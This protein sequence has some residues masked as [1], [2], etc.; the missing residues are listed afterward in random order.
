MIRSS[1][2]TVRFGLIG[3]CIAAACFAGC[4]ED[5]VQP[6]TEPGDEVV[7]NVVRLHLTNSAN[8][9]D[10]VSAGFRDPDG[11]GGVSGAVDTLQLKAGVVYGG[12][13]TAEFRGKWPTTQRDTVV[14][15]TEDYVTYGREHQFFYT[16]NGTDAER[17]AVAVID[18][19]SSNLPLGLKTVITVSSGDVGRATMHIELGHYDDA[20]RPKDGTR[21]PYE[22]DIDIVLPVL[23]R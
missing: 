1:K 6:G 10:T 2:R 19:D 3:A 21:T 11:D 17:V 18:K 9:A 13:L 15:L 4:K 23:I 14:D 16:M 20:A 7:P 8:P 12:S 5:P 22:R